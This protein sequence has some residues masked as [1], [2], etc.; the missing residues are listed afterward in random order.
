MQGTS[1]NSKERIHAALEGRPVDRMPATVLYNQLYH[2]DHFAELTG[3]PA[4]QRHAWNHAAP[5]EHV[6]VL[7][8]MI[9]QAPFEIIQPQG[10][11]TRE[12]RERTVFFEKEGTVFRRDLKTDT[13]TPVSASSAGHASDYAANEAQTVFGVRDF[14]ARFQLAKAERILE[15]G[16]LDYIHA[17]V[18]T[19]G[20]DHFICSGG[21]VSILWD[22]IPY[23]GQTNM[24]T[25]LID[26]P[27]LI[28][29]MGRKLLDQNIEKIRAFGD[30]G[31]DAL[32]IDDAMGYSDVI[33][34]AHYERFSLPYLKAMVQEIHR[35]GMKVILIY[36]GGVA[37]RLEQ[38]VSTGADGLSVETTMKNY[39]NDIHDISRKIGGR[40]ALFGNIDPVGILQNGSDA[41]LK[42]EI[43]RQAQAAKTARGFIMC[44]GSPI[45]PT[46]PLARVRLFIDL[47][48]HI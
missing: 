2:L 19:L 17:A 3:K 39:V 20:K 45:T 47:S 29:Y 28:E 1:L 30:V 8:Q 15:D 13:I 24:L 35:Q 21:F 25:M 12:M 38:I 11:S 37:D 40:I 41:Q 42:A 33:S 23:V 6:A 26:N 7:K 4:W 43:H 27:E 32:Y 14:N 48:Q 5:D 44:T 10:A 18:Q 22:C 16:S 31:G 46:T 9:A 36:F 34:V